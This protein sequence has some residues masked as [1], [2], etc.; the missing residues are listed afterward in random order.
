M[1]FDERLLLELAHAGRDEKR[2][3]VMVLDLD[4]FKD[5]NDTFG[6]TVGDRLLQAVGER[7]KASLRSSDT[8]AR[9]GGDEFLVLLPKIARPEDALGTAEKIL[10]AVR[11]PLAVDGQELRVTTSIGV[12][13]YPDDGEESETL[14][15]NADIAMYRAKEKGRN[16]YERYTPK[17]EG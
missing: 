14:V 13:L 12:A 16:N 10:D 1:A 8:V 15:K 2:L 5:V 7:L 9:L 11:R 4:R 17:A 3:A 6:H